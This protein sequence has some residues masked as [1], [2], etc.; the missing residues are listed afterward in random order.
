MRDAELF[1]W[2]REN[3]AAILAAVAQDPMVPVTA[4]PGWV[5]R[6]VLPHI[7]GW[8]AGWWRFNISHPPEEFD[9]ETSLGSAPPPPDDSAEWPAYFEHSAEAFLALAESLDL[10]APTWGFSE[11]RPARFWLGRI[12]TE[13]TVHRWDVERELGMPYELST[14]RAVASID[15]LLGTFVPIA[16]MLGAV[17][18]SG[19]LAVAPD[20]ADDRWVAVPVD[21]GMVV[22]P[23]DGESAG[24]TLTGPARSLLLRLSGRETADELRGPSDLVT[25]WEDVL[26]KMP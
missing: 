17:V 25:A 20:D 9:Y 10:T 18:P 3:N 26:A 19:P 4:C 15:D 13:T 22:R 2:I 14:E 23:G 16:G 21:G 8:Y 11:T 24:A 12:A 7:G 5:A 6:D 1:S